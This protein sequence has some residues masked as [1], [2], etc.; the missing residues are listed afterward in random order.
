MTINLSKAFL[1]LELENMDGWMGGGGVPRR[2]FYHCV[3]PLP[4]R[5]VVGNVACAQ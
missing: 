1:L 4:L 5:A 2:A 3:S